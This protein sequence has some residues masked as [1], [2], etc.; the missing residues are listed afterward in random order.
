MT[1]DVCPSRGRLVLV[2]LTPGCAQI[3]QHALRAAGDGAVVIVVAEM[4]R[5][6]DPRTATPAQHDLACIYPLLPGSALAPVLSTVALLSPG[7]ARLGCC[8]VA[9]WASAFVCALLDQCAAARLR[10]H[11]HSLPAER[12][13]DG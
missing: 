9:G 1:P 11:T 6:D 7:A 4:E 5:V 13:Q 2:C 10:A 12:D 3:A 8:T